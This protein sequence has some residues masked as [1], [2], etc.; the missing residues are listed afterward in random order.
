MEIEEYESY[1]CSGTQHLDDCPIQQYI[2][3]FL[4]V[5]G[6]IQ[7]IECCGRVMYHM[8]REEEDDNEGTKDVCIFFLVAWFIAGNVWVFGNYSRYD[9]MSS[10]LIGLNLKG[11]MC[12]IVKYNTWLLS[13]LVLCDWSLLL[14]YSYCVLVSVTLPSKPVIQLRLLPQIVGAMEGLVRSTV[15]I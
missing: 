2:P 3:I 11:S 8:S 7:M 12:G 9:I 5:M 6:V 14:V 13:V 10:K 15:M 4:V 1:V